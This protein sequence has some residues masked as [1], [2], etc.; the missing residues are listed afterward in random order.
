MKRRLEYIEYRLQLAKAIGLAI[1]VAQKREEMKKDNK[2][3]ARH[4]EP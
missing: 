1:F 4:T 2:S 3:L